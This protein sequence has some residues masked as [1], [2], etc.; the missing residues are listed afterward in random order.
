M[1][2]GTGDNWQSRYP[3]SNK[4]YIKMTEIYF[5]FRISRIIVLFFFSVRA[6]APFLLRTCYVISWFE[7]A[8]SS[9]SVNSSLS[10]GFFYKFY[11]SIVSFS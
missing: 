9:A 3:K 11:S 5:V 4:G 2:T 10:G 6:G 1:F 8:A 7:N